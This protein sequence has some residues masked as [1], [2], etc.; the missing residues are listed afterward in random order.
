LKQADCEK[1]GRTRGLSLKY[2]QVVLALKDLY[3]AGQ[4][5]TTKI[6]RYFSMAFRRTLYKVLKRVGVKI[7][8]FDQPIIGSSALTQ[9]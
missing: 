9:S 1:I 4:K 8:N 6:M 3:E 2:Q 5:S 7:K